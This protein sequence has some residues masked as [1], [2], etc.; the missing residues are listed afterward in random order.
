MKIGFKANQPIQYCTLW[1]GSG[2]DGGAGGE[3][4]SGAVGARGAPELV[5]PVLVVLHAGGR[6]AGLLAA[7]PAG[8]WWGD[9]WWAHIFGV[10]VHRFGRS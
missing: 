7:F 5:E 9:V 1:Q 8:W 6:P 2:G 10:E 4:G 3:A